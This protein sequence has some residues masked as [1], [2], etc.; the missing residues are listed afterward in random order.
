MKNGRSPSNSR[1]VIDDVN[2]S[3]HNS[4]YEDWER[5]EMETQRREA[6]EKLLKSSDGADSLPQYMLDLLASFERG[7]QPIEIAEAVPA[8]KLPCIAIIGRPNT[9]KSTLV[10]KISNSYKDGAIVHD[11]A[12]IT[13]DRTYRT[14]TWNDYNFQVVDTGGIVFDDNQDIFA[15]QITQQA[16]QALSEATAAIMVCDGKVGVTPLDATLSEWLRKKN[17]VPLYLAVNKCESETVGVTQ[18]QEFWQLGIGTPY[19][20][21]GIHGTGVGD[22]LDKIIADTKMEKV[23]NILKENATNIAL[24][25]RPNVGKSSLFNRLVGE[26]RSI[27]SNVA[28]TTRDAID[29]LVKHKGSEYRVMDTAGIRK[30]NKVSYGAEFF[31]IN[32]AFKAMKRADVVLLLLDAIDGIVD[33]DRILAERIAEEGRS[34]VIALNKWDAVPNKDDKT[35]LKAVENIR[36][37]LPVLRWAEVVLIS[38]TSGQRIDKLFEA[39]DRAAKQFSRRISTATL[40]E[41]VQDAV[42][43]MAP[44]TIGSRAGRIYYSLQTS[45]APPT[46]VMF[47]NDPALFTD[48]YKR[49]IDRKIRDTLDFEGTPLRILWRGKSLRDVGRAAQKGDQGTR[50][51][52]GG[53]ALGGGRQGQ[54]KISE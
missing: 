51:I 6:E 53:G 2:H 11:E 19:P 34:C 8:A 4:L 38:A 40:N 17:K 41:V 44:P 21:S 42:M 32:R 43:W 10:N 50:R 15:D 35:Y 46:I 9:G 27:V 47:V 28:G 49:Y 7:Q 36:S 29:A 3:T 13:R 52:T 54:R 30:R 12:G 45:T 20:V 37:T 14:A 22:L 25:G 23:S 26:E 48:S 24:V 1:D 39:V 33:Q 31:M 16:M 5:E 18:A